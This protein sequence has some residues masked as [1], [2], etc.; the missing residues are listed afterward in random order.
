MIPVFKKEDPLEKSN[1]R[2][3]TI[4]TAVD[5]LFEQL[6][7][8]QMSKFFESI[9]DPFMSAYRKLYSCESTLVHLIEGWKQSIDTGKTV[10]VLSTDMTKAFVTMHPTLL[11]A[12][13]QA[14]GFSNKESL[15]LMRSF[16][17]DRKG[18]AKLRAVVSDWKPINMGC[19]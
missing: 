16:F 12:K 9:F 14:Y 11:L 3:I 15:T 6:L 13:L 19:P 18:R 4:L 8:K 7:S 10:S 2:P 5:K 1:Y 17:M